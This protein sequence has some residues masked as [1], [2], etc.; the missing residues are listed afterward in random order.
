MLPGLAQGQGI[1]PPVTGHAKGQQAFARAGTA[2]GQVL[3]QPGNLLRMARQGQLGFGFHGVGQAQHRQRHAGLGQLADGLQGAVP[4]GQEHTVEAFIGR[5]RADPHLD[6]GNDPETAFAAQ[7]HFAQIRAGRR[8]RERRD[9][10]W[11]DEGFQGSAREQLL[12]TPVAQG[13]LATGATGHP[14]AQ[15]RQLPRLRKMPQGVAPCA[16]LT[17][18]LRPGGTGA[19]GG[20]QAL[21][22]EIEQATHARQGH[23]HHRPCGQRRVDVPGH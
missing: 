4:V 13:L 5:Q 22:I 21:L 15:G 8:G 20:Q 17:L 11:P 3:L 23:G 7:H 2:Q 9:F 18:H 10:Q 12:D 1:L 19:E 6:L 16:Q 14:A